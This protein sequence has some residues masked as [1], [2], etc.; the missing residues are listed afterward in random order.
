MTNSFSTYHLK[1]NADKSGFQQD[2]FSS[3]ASMN[4]YEFN[5]GWS[6][7]EDQEP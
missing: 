4:L 7:T 3:V 5:S 6:E 2:F 1:E